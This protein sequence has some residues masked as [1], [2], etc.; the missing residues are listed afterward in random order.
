[1]D[2]GHA[3]CLIQLHEIGEGVLAALMDHGLLSARLSR[4]LLDL[5]VRGGVRAR[6]VRVLL[7]PFAHHRP[8]AL[9]TNFTLAAHTVEALPSVQ[10]GLVLLVVVDL[11]RSAIDI[12]VAGV[13]LLLADRD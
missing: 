12:S 2:C 1:M 6:P 3:T 10:A 5:T 4:H 9:D 8:G 13:V 11:H 7:G